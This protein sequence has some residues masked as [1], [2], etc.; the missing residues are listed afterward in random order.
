MSRRVLL[1][2]L[3]IGLLAFGVG[4]GTFAWFTDTAKS[5]EN[6]FETGTLTIDVNSPMIATAD[7][8]NIY[9]SWDSGKIGYEVR[10]T[11]SLD[12]KYRMK[13]ESVDS[14]LYNGDYAI[15][16]SINGGEFVQIDEVGTVEIG[17][18]AAGQTGNLDLQFR[19]PEGADNDYQD[20]SASFTFVFE[21]TQVNNE[22][23]DGT[24]TVDD[25]T[26]GE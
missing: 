7:F 1:S 4:M 26:T 10:N 13:V 5:Q 19:L 25:G 21:A 14:I 23:W 20:E 11:G 18:I 15:E 12:F 24:F 8:D 6:L 3:L 22:A 2:V 17:E 16:V 9:P